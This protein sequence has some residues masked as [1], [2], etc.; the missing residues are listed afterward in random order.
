MC[1]GASSLGTTQRVGLALGD[2]TELV[3]WTGVEKYI[4]RGDNVHVSLGMPVLA[5][6]VR[7]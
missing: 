4:R 7:E 6:D 1:S 5:Y 3:A 2:G